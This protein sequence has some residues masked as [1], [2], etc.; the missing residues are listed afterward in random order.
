[1]LKFAKALAVGAVAAFSCA[2]SP[3]IQRQR[4]MLNPTVM[5]TLEHQS[6]SGTV[7]HSADD[8][9]FVLTNYHVIDEALDARQVSKDARQASKEARQASKEVAVIFWLMGPQGDTV[10]RSKQDADIVAWDKHRDLALLQIRDKS[11][12]A[13]AVAIVA[14]MDVK[15]LVGEDVYV[16]GAGMG[17][18]V[19]LT[20]GLLSVVDD[21]VSDNPA[22]L[23][24]S[25]VVHGNSGG[26]LWHRRDDG[27]YEMIGVPEAVAAEMIDSPFKQPIRTGVAT[28]SFA[29]PLNT[30]RSFLAA[31]GY[32]FLDG[33]GPRVV[34]SLGVK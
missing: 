7:L 31:G 30:V 5:V 28:M 17:H 20:E 2:M 12:R 15:L 27:H 34:Q 19:F 14:P 16:A 8:G 10:S 3:A 21:Q 6:G 1:M 33:S 32:D 9:T 23:T 24:S 18:R 25:P 22:L 11:F 26:S 4:E 29:I 13:P